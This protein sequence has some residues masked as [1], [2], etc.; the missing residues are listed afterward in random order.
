MN[1]KKMIVILILVFALV[2]FGASALYSRLSEENTPD[3]LATQ[4]TAPMTTTQPTVI[5]QVTENPPTD[6]PE[7]TEEAKLS[8]PDFTVYDAEGL[9]VRLSEFIGKPIVL[10]FWASWCG[11][12]QSEMPDFNEKAQTLEGQVQFL[13]INMT[14]GNRE[15][16]QTATD[17]VA[18]MGY[19]FPVYFD[20]TAQA[21]TVYSAYSLP[22]TYFIDADGYIVAQASGA[23][24]AE[25]LQRGIDMILS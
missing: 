16:V 1:N 23:I 20:T 4:S 6:P 15:T 21:A 22:T 2:L 25:T 14:D 17:F 8:A 18:G 13:M 7:T 12:C 11:P 24:D 10:N 3:Q 9:E 5:T 19:T